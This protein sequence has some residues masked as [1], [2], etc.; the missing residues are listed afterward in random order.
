MTKRRG[1][2]E[3]TIWYNPKLNRWIAQITLPRGKKKTKKGLTQ[4]EVKRW[5]LAQRK[6]IQDNHYLT[7]ESYTVASFLNRY[8]EDVA[9]HTLAPRTILSYRN[10]A[11]RHILPALGP[12]KLSQL[13]VEHLQRLYA[14]EMGVIPRQL[15]QVAD[16]GDHRSRGI[17]LAIFGLEGRF[18]LSRWNAGK[19]PK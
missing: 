8:L 10:L 3:G 15:G 6:A 16:I 2:G 5:L 1:R 12:V 18:Q 17:G 4:A 19:G 14:S 7:D 11:Y 9:A 13:R